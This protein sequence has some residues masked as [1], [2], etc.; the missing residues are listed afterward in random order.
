MIIHA[1]DPE[2]GEVR[3]AGNPVKI[4]GFDDPPERPAAPDLDA[5]RAAVLDLL[6]GRRR[7]S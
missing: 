2:A 4:S 3:M 7:D 5:D 6:H 1:T